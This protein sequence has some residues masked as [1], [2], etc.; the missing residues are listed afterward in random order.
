[1]S[2]ETSAAFDPAACRTAIKL[3]RE[4]ER[5]AAKLGKQI[6]TSRLAELNRKRDAGTITSN[7]LPG[8]LL[9]RFPGQFAGMTLRQI[10]LVCEL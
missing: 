7:D 2:H 10:V 1:M 4:Y 9:T 8:S 3:L 5:L 6:P